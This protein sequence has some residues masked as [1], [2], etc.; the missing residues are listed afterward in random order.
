MVHRGCA[1]G[2]DFCLASDIPACGGQPGMTC[3]ACP[4]T[5]KVVLNRVEGVNAVDVRYEER[6]ATVTF[7]DAKTSVEALTQATTNAGYPSTLKQSQ[8][9]QE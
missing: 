7:D 2:N 1:G 9:T 5:V 4:I 6:D 3:S 8:A